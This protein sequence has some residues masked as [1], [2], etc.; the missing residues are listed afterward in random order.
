MLEMCVD[1]L[2]LSNFE[3]TVVY[4]YI[5]LQVE[6]MKF[7]KN[8]YSN[9]RFVTSFLVGQEHLDARDNDWPYDKRA[10]VIYISVRR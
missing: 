5:L 4:R 1:M 7:N 2:L 3:Q 8:P 6:N 10:I 9:H